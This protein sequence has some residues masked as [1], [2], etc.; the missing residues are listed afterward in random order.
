[1]IL[2]FRCLPHFTDPV[3]VITFNHEGDACCVELSILPGRCEYK[4]ELLKGHYARAATALPSGLPRGS[5][6]AS[7][8]NASTCAETR[9]DLSM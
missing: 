3:T 6:N 1:M 8:K 4:S 2:K 7:Q 9:S 5:V